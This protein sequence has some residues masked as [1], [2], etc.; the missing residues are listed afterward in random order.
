[1]K[2]FC[3]RIWWRR[4]LCRHSPSWVSTLAISFLEMMKSCT[5]VMNRSF[6]VWYVIDDPDIRPVL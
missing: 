6:V 1:M 4:V 2:I 3:Q 5:V